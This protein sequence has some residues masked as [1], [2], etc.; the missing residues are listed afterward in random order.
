LE[1]TLRCV[2]LPAG[3]ALP[4]LPRLQFPAY[5]VFSQP[6]FAAVER[7][8]RH[9]KGSVLASTRKWAFRL[10]FRSLCELSGGGLAQGGEGGGGPAAVLVARGQLAGRARMPLLSATTCVIVSV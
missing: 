4:P 8:I 7:T 6:V 9:R 5:Q 10:T 3:L 2:T 1:G